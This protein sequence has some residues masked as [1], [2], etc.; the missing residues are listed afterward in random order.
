MKSDKD[1]VDFTQV[2]FLDS[3]WSCCLSPAVGILLLDFDNTYLV[4]KYIQNIFMANSLCWSENLWF[5]VK[6]DGV[7]LIDL[8]LKIT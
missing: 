5:L 7:I 3:I 1:G 8:T 6:F 4:K 2:S